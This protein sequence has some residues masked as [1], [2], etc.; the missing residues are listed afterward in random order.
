MQ[1]DRLEEKLRTSL[2]NYPSPMDLEGAWSKLERTRNQRKKRRGAWFWWLG[3][4]GMIL[5][6]FIFLLPDALDDGPAIDAIATAKSEEDKLAP[7]VNSQKIKTTSTLEPKN[8]GEAKNSMQRE[9][10]GKGQTASQSAG[11]GVTSFASVSQESPTVD[12][13]YAVPAFKKSPEIE[14][15]AIDDPSSVYSSSLT[16]PVRQRLANLPSRSFLPLSGSQVEGFTA[17]ALKEALSRRTRRQSDGAW[18]IGFSSTAGIQQRTLK[19]STASNA[20]L[21]SLLTRRE[22]SETVM[23]AYSFS[24]D[25][26]KDFRSNW[27][28]QTGI[29]HQVAFERFEDQYERTFDK[30]LEDQVT[31]IIQRADGTTTEIRGEVTVPVTESAKTVIY[32]TQNLTE[33]PILV[34]YRQQ[35]TRSMGL[36]LNLGVLYGFV[37]RKE[38]KV[39]A[40]AN[41]IG[42]YQSLAQMPYRQSNLWGAQVQGAISY[43]LSER[44]RFLGGVQAKAY[45]N[46]V[47]AN[48][49]FQERQILFNGLI[50]LQFQ[51]GQ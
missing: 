21:A 22:G 50:G 19:A 9:L 24:F 29:R 17:L 15:G 30:V 48:A 8:S 40:D 2:G 33:L 25:V 31:E 49:A 47:K 41:A 14:G 4:A 26:R 46:T 7:T 43:R 27:Y 1:K 5:C 38:G 3:A 45:P 6:L 20:E 37:Q 11:Q 13:R 44:W 51:L 42:E 28:V 36:D 12:N 39:H 34:G 10:R 32:N 23:E 35:L 16:S 18:W